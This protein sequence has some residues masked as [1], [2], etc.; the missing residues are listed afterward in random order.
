MGPNILPIYKGHFVDARLRQFHVW[1]M[2]ALPSI[3]PFESPKGKKWLAEMQQHGLSIESVPVESPEGQQRL[4][5]F[6]K[7]KVLG[8]R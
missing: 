8:S 1:K 3:I 5:Q 2:G 6:R 4:E 7:L